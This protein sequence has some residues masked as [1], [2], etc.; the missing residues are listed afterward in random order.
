MSKTEFVVP[1]LF[2]LIGVFLLGYF[3]AELSLINALVSMGYAISFLV[4]VDFAYLP[5]E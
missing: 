4:Y 3:D 5:D 1:L 2:A